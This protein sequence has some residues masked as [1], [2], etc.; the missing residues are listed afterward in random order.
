MASVERDLADL[1][2]SADA[3][4]ALARGA[5]VV[6]AG[7]VNAGKSSL[8]NV[9]LGRERAIVSPAPGTTR[10]FIEAEVEW[11]GL[12]L[13]LVDTAGERAAAAPDPVE[14]EGQ[15][16]GSGLRDEADLVIWLLDASADVPLL[17]P[18]TPAGAPPCIVAW[19]K[20]DLHDGG[21]HSPAAANAADDQVAISAR[22]GAGLEAL[23]RR[24]LALLAPGWDQSE[25]PLVGRLR[26]KR[27]LEQAL[28]AVREARSLAAAG[29]G[30]EILV[31]P[32]GRALASLA[33]LTGRGDL[34]EVYDRIFSTFCIGK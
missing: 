30:E 4:M 32:L 3:G 20:I 14:A 13:T 22:T 5:R 25:P 9:L 17:P 11:D 21:R 10:D 12:P 28:A 23:R 2:A 29:A 7:A 31:E 1:L 24:A 33:D 8:F 19:N 6:L 34:E 18:A 16:R 27:C 26:Q 15:R